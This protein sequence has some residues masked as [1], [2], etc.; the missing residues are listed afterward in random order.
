MK[1]QEILIKIVAYIIIIIFCLISFIPFITGLI[2]AFKPETIQI[3]S[4]PIWI[5]EPT[6][7]NYDRILFTKGNLYN[8]M[9]SFIVTLINIIISLVVGIPA[10]YALARFNLKGSGALLSWII[11]LRMIPPV[12]VAIPFFSLAQSFNLYDTYIG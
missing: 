4:P 6:L 3:H 12:V 7:S 11:S 5:F 9:N 2:T 1:N 8:L 10:A